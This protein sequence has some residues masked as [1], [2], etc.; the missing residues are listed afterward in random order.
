MLKWRYISG[1]VACRIYTCCDSYNLYKKD[2]NAMIQLGFMYT[3]SEI[4]QVLIRQ[5]IIEHNVH[6]VHR[7]R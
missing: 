7:S 6:N 3:S 4:M 1:A 2:S 5:I